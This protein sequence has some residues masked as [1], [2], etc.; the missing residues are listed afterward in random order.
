MN[1]ILSILRW[2]LFLS[3]HIICHDRPIFISELFMHTLLVYLKHV[4]ER[5]N[6]IEPHVRPVAGLSKILAL[7]YESVDSDSLT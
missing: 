1:P 2:L 5:L 4:H 6:F 3:E 7:L